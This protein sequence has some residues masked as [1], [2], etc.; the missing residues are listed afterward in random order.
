MKAPA[1]IPVPNGRYPSIQYSS[2]TWHLWLWFGDESLTR[3]FS[4]S[5]FEGPYEA[6]DA[7]P[8]GLAD[9]HVRKARDGRYFAAYK[10]LRDGAQLASGLLTATSLD[11]PWKDLGHIFTNSRDAWHAGEEADPAFFDRNG[12][13]YVTFAGWNG[14]DPAKDQKIGIVEVDPR[15]G[16]AIGSAT[17]LLE[18]KEPWHLRNGQHKLFNPVFLCDGGRSRLFFA[19]NVSA[20]GVPAGWGYVEANAGCRR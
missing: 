7:L 19:Q 10:D 9:I 12:K 13:S 5:K 1:F 6:R 3:H 14:L 2:G 4:S 20:S 15:T 8:L 17:V 16:K 11:G 18:A